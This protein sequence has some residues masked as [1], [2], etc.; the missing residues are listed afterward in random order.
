MADKPVK[1]QLVLVLIHI[2]MLGIIIIIVFS[3]IT[4]TMLIP[5]K[6]KKQVP[7]SMEI[8]NVDLMHL[9]APEHLC[10]EKGRLK[11]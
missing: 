7:L 8:E 11:K 1:I 5:E 4:K 2:Y 10:M 9:C 6:Q 3:L